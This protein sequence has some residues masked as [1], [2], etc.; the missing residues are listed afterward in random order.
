MPK[1]SEF[2]AYVGVVEEGIEVTILPRESDPTV[3]R[4][5]GEKMAITYIYDTT[6]TKLKKMSYNR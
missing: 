3:Y 4:G 2:G 6:G 1:V 5:K